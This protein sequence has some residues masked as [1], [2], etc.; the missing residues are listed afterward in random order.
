MG[1][2]MDIKWSYYL[3]ALVYILVILL[4]CINNGIASQFKNEHQG[5][6]RLVV[7]KRDFFTTVSVICA[8]TAIFINTAALSGGKSINIPSILVT[9]LVIGFTLINSVIYLFVAP[10]EEKILLTGYQLE[11]GEIENV[12][13]KERRGFSSYDITFTKEIDSY[14]YAKLTVFGKARNELKT[15][16]LKLVKED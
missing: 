12:K 8:A 16:I 3:I 2:K 6:I 1:K 4:K 14:N 15:T 9:L 13:V 11:R 7:L 10:N 5:V